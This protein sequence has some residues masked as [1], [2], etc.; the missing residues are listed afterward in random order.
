VLYFLL[1]VLYIYNSVIFSITALHEDGKTAWST[2]PSWM[3]PLILSAPFCAVV[4]LLTCFGQT[5]AHLLKIKS[6][7]ASAFHDQVIQVLALPALY[8]GMA[9]SS[10][11]RMYQFHVHTS[12]DPSF[13]N[14]PLQ[15]QRSV[16]LS[17]SETCFFVG[18]MF[19]AWT[20]Y[21]FGRMTLDVIEASLQRQSREGATEKRAEARGMMKSHYAIWAM[22]WAS[23][24]IFLLVSFSETAWSLYLLHIAYGTND[25]LEDSLSVFTGAGFIASGAALWNI[26]VVERN[27]HENLEGFWPLLKFVTVKILVSFAYFQKGCFYFL[28]ALK[29]TLPEEGQKLANSVPFFG[30]VMSMDQAH[31]DL[32]YAT[33]MVLECFL[34]SGLHLIAWPAGEDWYEKTAP[35]EKTALLKDEKA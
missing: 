33:L 18:D 6:G 7:S 21:H 16:A 15:K 9:F 28:V 10:M 31:F 23:V 11:V 20:L 22:V 3:R 1:L 5:G 4:T 25:E 26:A 12:D 34:V 13:L 24:V 17:R 30:Q 8:G 32:F 2:L 27:F 35:D 14:L 29:R 19:E